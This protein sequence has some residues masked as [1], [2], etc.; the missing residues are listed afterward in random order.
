MSLEPTDPEVKRLLMP[1]EEIL[2]TAWQ[3]RGVPGGSIST[4]NA[5]YVT[6]IRIIFKNP[7]LFGWKA[8]IV[9]VHYRDI[10]N[11]WLKRGVFSTEIFLKSRHHSDQVKLPGVDKQMANQVF[12]MIQKG[13]RREL[14]RQIFAEDKSNPQTSSSRNDLSNLEEIKK[15]AELK[16]TGAIT[17]EEFMQMK[18]H[19]L[20]KFSFTEPEVVN[21]NMDSS[22]RPNANKKFGAPL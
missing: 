1:E 2:L 11:I 4:P 8:N 3:S 18:S 6:N 13:V 10:S 12:S 7:R 9:D 21:R 15:L 5:I 17:E 22:Q 20:K 14:P 19:I 16:Q